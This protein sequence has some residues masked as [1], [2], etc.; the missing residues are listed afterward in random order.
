MLS[1]TR[2]HFQTGFSKSIR[3]ISTALQFVSTLLTVSKRFKVPGITSNILRNKSA[4]V[5]GIFR[6]F[7]VQTLRPQ[8]R[9]FVHAKEDFLLPHLYHF[10]SHSF[11]NRKSLDFDYLKSR[12]S[13]YIAIIP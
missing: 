11:S 4:L 3:S 6:T 7:C 1:C 12:Y 2:H 13:V 8:K 5:M 9:G 10:D